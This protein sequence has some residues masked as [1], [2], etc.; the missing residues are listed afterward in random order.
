MSPRPVALPVRPSGVP[1]A[2]RNQR[3]WSTWRY[4]WEVKTESK[5]RW[6]KRPACRT[7]DPSTWTDF[8]SALSAHERGGS[9]GL[10]FNLGDGWAGADL[11]HCR[12]AATGAL[13]PDAQRVVDLLD[14]YAE[15]SPSGTGVKAFFRAARVGF[16]I[17]FTAGPVLTP[18]QKARGFTV[19]GHGSGDPNVV[20][21]RVLDDLLP[22]VQPPSQPRRSGF[23]QA[24]TYED[25]DVLAGAYASPQG[26]KFMSLWRGDAAAY[27]NDHSRADQALCCILAWWTNYDMDRVDR[28]F[29]Q[30]G[31][32][33]AKWNS[34]SYRRATLARA[35]Q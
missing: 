8:G 10:W 9:D 26:A 3:R 4:D 25:V 21:D 15:A 23:E 5:G 11:D 13:L 17:D 16:Q 22:R 20:R 7:N 2:L 32:M 27:G 35:I 14:C 30:S 6:I 1:A 28:L 18:W 34:D 12:D 19:T 24:A 31:L 33:R 29:R